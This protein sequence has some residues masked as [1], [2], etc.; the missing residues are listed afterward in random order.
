MVRENAYKVRTQ[1]AWAVFA[2]LV[3]LSLGALAAG[4]FVLSVN[5]SVGGVVRSNPAG[6]D[7]GGTCVYPFAEGAVIS[8]LPSPAIGYVFTG[9]S[10]ACQGISA[11]NITLDQS[12]QVV[13]HFA[14]LFS[15][16]FYHS[17]AIKDGYVW[18]WGKNNYGQFGDQET[19][20]TNTPIR[21]PGIGEVVT[22]D[23]GWYHALALKSDGTVV[24]WG[25]NASGQL[26]VGNDPYARGP[27]FVHD[28]DHVVAISANGNQ[29]M[30]LKSDGTVWAWGDNKLGTQDTP[31]QVVGLSDVV[32]IA[33][34]AYHG[35]A[36]KFDGTVWAWGYGNYGQ[37]GNGSNFSGGPVLVSNL[38]GI[39]A[40]DAGNLYSMALKSDGT[41]WAWGY[42]I[43]GQFGRGDTEESNVPVQA[44]GMSDI[45]AI[46]TASDHSTVMRTDGSLWAAGYGQLGE[47]GNGQ[48]EISLFPV[49]VSNFQGVA[50]ISGGGHHTL[51]IKGD[52]SLWSWGHGYYGELGNGTNESSN[53]PVAVTDMV[54]KSNTPPIARAAFN[55]FV[56]VSERAVL[57]GSMSSDD[58]GDPLTYHW[59]LADKPDGSSAALDDPM[60]IRPSFVADKV[61]GYVVNLVVNDGKVDSQIDSLTIYPLKTV[62]VANAGNDQHVNVGGIATLDGSGSTDRDGDPLTYVWAMLSEPDGSS[63]A[64]TDTTIVNPSFTVDKAGEY[65]VG[66]VVSDGLAESLADTVVVSTINVAPVA[67][68]GTD[69]AIT[70]AG[71][72]VGLDGT[73]SY[74]PDDDAISHQ[75]SFVSKP[76]GSN[77][78]LTGDTTSQPTFV[79]DAYGEYVV[80]LTVRDAAL[81]SS[82]NVTVSFSNVRPVA[83]AGTGTSVIVGNKVALNGGAS[84]DA[85]GDLLSYQWVLS[86]VPL[87][88]LA[89]I[90]DPAGMTTEFTPDVA[91]TYTVQLTVNDGLLFSAPDA[92]Q[93]LAV[94]PAVTVSPAV[95]ALQSTETLIA[96]LG[97]SIFKNANMGDMLIAKL[98]AVIASIESRKYRSALNRLR[99]DIGR[100]MDG[101]S[102]RGK[103]DRN[104]WITDCSAQ[105]LVYTSLVNAIT[106]IKNRS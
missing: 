77:A 99:N 7:C 91:G 17:H 104:D 105:T 49:Q 63:A 37:L 42:N 29:S 76:T 24:A 69:Q 103:P 25:Y 94:S 38:N 93:I 83:G 45:A 30:A 56:V 70:L 106:A 41:V 51:A 47:L 32:A 78:I 44:F 15:S 60:A 36:L 58:D 34:G 97:T 11:C 81:S 5:K 62:P 55:G 8:L 88:S 89:V 57:D 52:G 40:I 18:S 19:A 84:S 1:I 74:D 2:I 4:D 46:G 72:T 80:Q 26:G 101:C 20:S 12:R 16:G 10:G 87:G 59:T 66:L 73:K 50:P 92:I 6:I 86:S 33:A 90:A 96:G 13:A 43:Y 39:T 48:N 21:I 68:A 98:N 61:G 102:R 53:V 65:I 23:A 35:I 3:G 71:T 79:A 82:D 100:K 85:N 95:S 64:L 27:D 9:W 67:D 14:P 22:V 28:L 54:F 75:W 31:Q